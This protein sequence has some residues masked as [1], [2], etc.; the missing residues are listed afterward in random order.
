MIRRKSRA[1]LIAHS[2]QCP[3]RLARDPGGGNPRK[4]L[5]TMGRSAGAC[6]PASNLSKRRGIAT[7]AGL[8]WPGWNRCIHGS[9]TLATIRGSPRSSKIAAALT[10]PE[11]GGRAHGGY[12]SFCN[13]EGGMSADVVSLPINR[14]LGETD[15]Q[16]RL[17]RVSAIF[18]AI[19]AGDLLAALPEC[20]IARAHHAAALSLLAMAEVEIHA[21]EAQLEDEH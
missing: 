4:K 9:L 15:V 16:E 3:G 21:I 1:T 10:Q 12:C 17:R 5:P 20:A 11:E 18:F 7:L 8:I 2:T 14:S 19:D 13:F 6:R